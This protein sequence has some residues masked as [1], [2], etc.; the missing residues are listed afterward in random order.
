[1]MQAHRHW[2]LALWLLLGPTMLLVIW[3]ALA[4]R[5]PAAVNDSLPPSLTT[6][7]DEATDE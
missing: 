1:M 5:P 4:L 7:L 6:A 3:F 2:H